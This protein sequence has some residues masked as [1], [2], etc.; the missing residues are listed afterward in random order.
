MSIVF[1]KCLIRRAAVTVGILFIAATPI[2]SE[3]LSVPTGNV[4]LTVSGKIGLTNVGQSA[5]F[6]M[7]MLMALPAKEFE[8]TTIWTRG[9][10]RFRGVA[11]K[12]LIDFLGMSGT[13]MSATAINDYS[14]DF[15]I[16]AAREDGPMIAYLLNGKTMSRRDKGPLWI[17]FPY[18]TSASFQTET[19]YSRSIWQLDRINVE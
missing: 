2:W 1:L 8:T 14:I 18:D 7:K 19:T 17:V 12:E 13:T 16:S 15:P 6:D 4:V 11:L 3:Q 9:P 5:Q 10:Q